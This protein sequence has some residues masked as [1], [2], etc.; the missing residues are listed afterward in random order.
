MLPWKTYQTIPQV[1]LVQLFAGSP[2]EAVGRE[3]GPHSLKRLPRE[4]RGAGLRPIEGRP[5]EGRSIS[6]H[7]RR[8]HKPLGHLAR[9]EL[10]YGWIS[11]CGKEVDM[12]QLGT[13]QCPQHQQ[14]LRL[15]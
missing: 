1:M 8:A 12:R 3:V 10:G 4:V 13:C 14:A 5:K 15:R 2:H 6:S 9:V 7:L 11:V